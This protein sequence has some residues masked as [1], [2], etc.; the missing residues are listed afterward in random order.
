[1]NYDKNAL[2]TTQREYF[3]I[4]EKMR[5]EIVA[6]G[7]RGAYI[8]KDKEDRC[9]FDVIYPEGKHTHKI[10]RDYAGNV[11]VSRRPYGY[12]PSVSSHVRGEIWSKYKGGN[13][14]VITAKKLQDKI[15]A[16]N[17]YHLEMQQ[18]ENDAR[19]SHASFL[20]EIEQLGLNFTYGREDYND[21][22]SAIK[23][24]RIAKNGIAFTFELGQ[25][26]Y[27]SKKIEIDYTVSHSLDNFIKLSDN[28]L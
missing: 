25:D 22:K 8:E 9:T 3:T 23:S 26:G 2:D 17:A 19:M 5:D 24:G 12:F 4:A 11:Q 21:A 18:K 10:F 14:K 13:I 6:L 7:F 1:M 20:R 28:K 27:I 15:D 16:E